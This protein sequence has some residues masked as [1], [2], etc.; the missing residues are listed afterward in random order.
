MKITF[1]GGNYEYHRQYRLVDFWWFT[2]GNRLCFGRPCLVRDH[3]RDSVW[4]GGFQDGW[5]RFSAI[6]QIRRLDTEWSG[7]SR[8][9]F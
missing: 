3:R 2:G 4:A 9:G 6:R 1:I 7:L 5:Y 8:I